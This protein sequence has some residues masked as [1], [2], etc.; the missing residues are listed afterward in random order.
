MRRS[1]RG[2]RA[3]GQSKAHDGNQAHRPKYSDARHASRC[4]GTGWPPQS[5]HR[6]SSPRGR[7]IGMLEADQGRRVRAPYLAPRPPSTS[8]TPH[9]RARSSLLRR[10]RVGAAI[11]SA[12]ARSTG[13]YVSV[14]VGLDVSWRS[15]AG[16]SGSSGRPGQPLRVP[17]KQ[18]PSDRCPFTLPRGRDHAV[19]SRFRPDQAPEFRDLGVTAEIRRG[20]Q[21]RSRVS[22]Q[23]Q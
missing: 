10:S 16:L 18:P 17:R 2:S 7:V 3:H 6:L 8:E 4:T 21:S 9:R 23:P 19:R 11:R 14:A 15:A 20:G 12:S 5:G 13:S 1:D 22:C